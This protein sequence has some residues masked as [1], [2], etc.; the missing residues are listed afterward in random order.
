VLE[1]L[2]VQEVVEAS[3]HVAEGQEAVEEPVAEVE[4]ELQK[5][6]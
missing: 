1:L 3:M 2:E 4:G 5:E 6:L